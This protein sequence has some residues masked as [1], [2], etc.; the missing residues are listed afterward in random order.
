MKSLICLIIGALYFCSFAKAQLVAEFETNRGTFY[1][2]MD[3]VNAPLACA[4]FVLLSG[5]G[6][7]VWESPLGAA[8]PT[9]SLYS[10]TAE[11]DA[12]RLQLNLRY[13]AAGIGSP[14]RYE[15]Y[16]QNTYLG[17]VGIAASGGGVHQD[18]TGYERFEMKQIEFNPNK[19]QIR[20]KYRRPWIDSRFQFVRPAPMFENIPITRVEQ[21]KRFFSGSFTNNDFEHPGYQFQDENIRVSGNPNNP[22]GTVFNS[23][24]ILAMDSRGPNTNGSRFFIT[25]V[26]E[27]AWNGEYTPIGVVQQNAGRQVVQN[28]VN[29]A[30]HDNGVP[31]EP[32]VIRSISFTYA[33][34]ALAFF[35]SYHQ[36]FLPGFIEPIP[37]EIKR[38]GGVLSLVTPLRPRSQTIV[39]TGEDLLN[40]QPGLLQAQPFDITEPPTSE[41]FQVT[42]KRFY[43]AYATSLPNW[44]SEDIDFHNAR[45]YFKVNSDNASGTVVMDFH[46]DG[47]GG[48]TATYSA[49]TVTEQFVLDGEP[50][51]VVTNGS[52]TAIVTYDH[53]PGPYK[54][55]MTL[56][57]TSGPLEM[58][59]FTL[60]FESLPGLPIV[61]SFSALKSD[62]GPFYLGYSGHYQKLN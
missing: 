17:S 19:Y 48:I 9:S 46:V 6:D 1:V 34:G 45:Y 26:P 38:D 27:P 4:N 40:Y 5:K 3:Y 44:P 2:N 52:G 29:S 59:E 54:G 11:S 28:I 41:I 15:I 57:V 62:T 23:A 21:G 31:N 7:D 60:N 58:D 18:L 22:Y 20:F 14:E 32:M 43:K 36:G 8:S 37:L 13:V 33:G 53:S 12:P 10:Y 35:E 50:N 16:Q 51:T 24:W 56:L 25:A 49:Q 61:R 55:K 47:G 42:Q 30:T 39:Y